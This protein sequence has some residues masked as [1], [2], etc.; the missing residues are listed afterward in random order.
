MAISTYNNGANPVIDFPRLLMRDTN[1]ASPVFTDGEILAGY[2]IIGS[3]FQ[4]GQYFSGP[5]GRN[6]PINPVNYLRV[7]GLL[8][9]SVA[10]NQAQT[11]LVQQLL[12][13]KLQD[14]AKAV[15]AVQAVAQRYLDMDDNSGAFFIAEQVNTGWA[16]IDRY[17]L[18][19]Q[20]QTG[21]F[22]G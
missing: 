1:M 15:A 22:I 10:A 16:F 20:R 13:V 12:D 4:S 8:L 6:L 2:Q 19:V 11:L 5:G 9:N 18:Q 3:V 14:I 7:A 21:G 17:W